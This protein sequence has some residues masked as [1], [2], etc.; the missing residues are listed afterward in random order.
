M[1]WIIIGVLW[2]GLCVVYCVVVCCGVVYVGCMCSVVLCVVW[3]DMVHVW[4]G[5]VWGVLCAVMW[6]GGFVVWC[7]MVYVWC[8]VYDMVSGVVLFVWLCWVCV[9]WC[10]I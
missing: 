1:V 2:C 4:N 7:D 9:V 10:M 3:Y 8:G 6:F 5:V